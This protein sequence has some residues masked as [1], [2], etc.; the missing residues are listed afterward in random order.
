M[1]SG[2]ERTLQRNGIGN[3]AGTKIN[4]GNR[5]IDLSLAG[6]DSTVMEYSDKK[7]V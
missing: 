7:E 6:D 4:P 3:R 2:T 1:K 5:A